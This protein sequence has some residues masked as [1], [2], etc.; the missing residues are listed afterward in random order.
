MRLALAGDDS[1]VRPWDLAGRELLALRGHEEVTR[2]VA[3][4]RDGHRL[5]SAD[6]DWTINV[7]DGIPVDDASAARE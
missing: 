2:D 7:W 1:A 3:F 4:S 5:G 6:Y